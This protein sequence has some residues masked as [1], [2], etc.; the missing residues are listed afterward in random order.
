MKRSLFGYRRTTKALA[1]FGDWDIYD[2]KITTPQKDDYNNNLLPPN[3]FD[4]N[5]SEL[6][7]PSPGFPPNHPLVQKAQNLM[8]EYDFFASKM[9]YSIWISGTNGKTTTT[10]MIAHLLAP[11]GAIAGGNIGT[12]LAELNPNAPL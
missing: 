4:P 11:Q 12:P 9:P 8:S 3:D 1:T 6:E 7:I 10:Q 5:R 2:D